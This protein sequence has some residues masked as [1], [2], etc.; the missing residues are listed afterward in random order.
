M[1]ADVE[2]IVIGAGVVGLAIGRALALAGHRVLVLERHGRIGTETS[3][4]NSEVIHAGL[5]YPP[6]SLRAKLCVSGKALLYRFCAE[7]SVAHLTCGKL[8]VATE[9]SE[10]SKLE[11]IAANA[12]ANGVADLRGLPAEEARALEPE[13]SC[14]AAY[15]S[16]STGVVDTA[17]LVQAIEGHLTTL[18]GE[19]VPNAAATRIDAPRSETADFAIEVASGGETS[20]LT[21]RN[22]VIAAGLGATALGRTLRYPQGYRVPETYPA[23]GHYFA[24]SGRAPFRHL[25]YPMPQGAWLGV[26]LTFDVARRARFGPDIQWTNGVSYHFEDADGARRAR[27]ERAIRRYWPGLPDDAL[28]PDSVG[29]RPKIYREGEPVADFAIDGPAAHGIPRLVALYGIE[30]PGLT[31]SLAIGEHVTA[32]LKQ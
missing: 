28:T 1:P 10:I 27:F 20:A 21:A 2:T 16:P 4:R 7:I 14:V 3:A 17:G 30:S 11:A 9:D 22:V 26:H 15:L 19:V 32:L 8:L 6:G 5:Y 18:G 24:L 23:K 12:K 29:V 25:V 13:L 31:S